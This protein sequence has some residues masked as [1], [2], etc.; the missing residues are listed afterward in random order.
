[1]P[2]EVMLTI[3]W[4][5]LSHVELEPAHCGDES[6]E[7]D[8]GY[9]GTISADDF[10]LRVSEAADGEEAVRQVLDFAAALSDATAAQGR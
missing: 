5:V 10:S 4:N 8:H 7:A 9:V 6:C 1:M 2:S 3:G